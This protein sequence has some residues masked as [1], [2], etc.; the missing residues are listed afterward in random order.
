[1]ETAIT[2]KT[3]EPIRDRFVKLT[4]EDTFNKEA[5]FALQ[6]LANNKYLAELDK[7]SII[8]AVLNVSQ[9]GLSL[10]PILKL[11]Y[12]IP[13]KGKC[14]L[15]VSYMGLVKLLTDTGSIKSVYAH[16]VYEGDE[17]EVILG[18]STEIIH[19]PKFNTKL[20][21]KVYAVSVLHDGSKQIEVMTASEINE[22]RDK[23]ESYMAY[24]AKKIKSCIWVDNYSE[25][26]RKTVIKRIAKYLPKT[27]R[28]EQFAQA[29]HIDNQ[30]YIISNEHANYLESLTETSVYDPETQE[31]LISKLHSGITTEEAE[32]IKKDLM[33][34]QRNPITSGTNY[35]QTDIKNHLKELSKNV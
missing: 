8:Q 34:N 14:C 26:A 27:D 1:M 11:A 20:L 12:L 30:D 9:T 29:V 32:T 19:K 16:P 7:N 17:F 22:I 21:Q 31:M 33:L 25:M 35:T 4:N 24:V 10:N 18:T 23:S 13:R 15:D 28:M 2:I 6:H 5:S 3:F